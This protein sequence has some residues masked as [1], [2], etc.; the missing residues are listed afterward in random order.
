MNSFAFCNVKGG[1]GKSN[2]AIQ[3]SGFISELGYKVL[4]IDGDPQHN[5]TK[6][7]LD[8]TP[9][10][11]LM[12]LLC[13]ECTF[14]ETIQQPYPNSSKLK[15]IYL[16]PCN[17]DLF[18]FLDDKSP[19]QALKFKSIMDNA[20][21]NNLL[22]YDFIFVD[23]N[24][25][26]TL[27]STSILLYVKNIVG[28]FDSSLDSMEGFRF[29]ESKIIKPIQE[30]TNPDLKLFGV[31]LNNNDRRTNFSME[32]I[33]SMVRLYGDAVFDTIISPSVK[34]KESRAMRLPLAE[35]DPKHNSSIQ[36]SQLAKEFVQRVG[37]VN[38]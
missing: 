19:N 24:P 23:T 34:N 10:K 18:F 12:E 1:V 16:L 21:R 37:V 14:E 6:A 3:L 17:Y 29:L 22:D 30:S 9:T 8:T 27:I 20:Q 5:L 35:Y 13:D 4:C 33:K 32:M 15:N 2:S 28:V 38:G 25:A 26:I 31:V 7:F 36:F 11:G